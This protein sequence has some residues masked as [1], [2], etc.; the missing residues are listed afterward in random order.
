MSLQVWLPL[1]GDLHNQGLLEDLSINST[2][3]SFLD[4]GKIGKCFTGYT[5][6]FNIP[7]FTGKKQISVAYW[8]K[9]N[10]A[11]ATD[12]LDAFRW[13]S[14]DGST[15]SMSRNEFYTNCTKTGFWFA[16]SPNGIGEKATT[17][18]EWHHH[19]FIIDYSAGTA[20]FYINGVSV[21]AVT[22]VY[23]T[24]SL[25]GENF[26]IGENGLDL[27]INDLRI[28]DHCL[29]PKEVKELSKGLAAH[30][31]LNDVFYYYTELDDSNIYDASGYKNHGYSKFSPVV[32]YESPR[33][34]IST[35]FTRPDLDTFT[36]NAFPCIFSGDF[37][38]SIWIRSKSDGRR[39]VIFSNFGIDGG[40][41]LLN[42]EK[43]ADDKIRFIW[44]NGKPDKTA[45][46]TIKESDGFVLVTITKSGNTLKVY[47]NGIL[48]D[49]FTDSG[50][51]TATVL[52][53]ATT[54]L[55]TADGYDDNDV[56]FAGSLSDFRI[57]ATALSDTDIEELYKVVASVDNNGNVYAYEINEEV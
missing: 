1:N 30:Y 21:G 44:N 49:T 25:T 17:V 47:K 56:W 16:G 14:T 51:S 3:V 39:S 50:Y 2:N 13:Y 48:T 55:L 32:D 42:L 36:S 7:Y 52:T 22:G 26:M 24:H 20:E 5:G 46:F 27:S 23:K 34:W 10:T 6:Y 35:E 19:A 53:T 54:F 18:G 41:N 33:Y 8:V 45:S 31:T 37:T 15:T 38:L 4:N 57:Y 9:V 43:T 40:G 12:W 29:S 28:Y 11:T